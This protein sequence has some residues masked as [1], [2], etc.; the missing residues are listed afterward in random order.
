VR[1]HWRRVS[2]PLPWAAFASI[3]EGGLFLAGACFAPALAR[4]GTASRG[5]DEADGA[6][7]SGRAEMEL[8][9]RPDFRII[10]PA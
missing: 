3:G 7:R 9:G 1:R 8:G 6:I 5:I 10:E 2:R 4:N